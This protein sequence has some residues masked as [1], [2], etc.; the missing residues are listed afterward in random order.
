MKLDEMKEW[1]KASQKA[2]EDAPS[3]FGVF[4]DMR[5]LAPLPPDAQEAMQEGQKLFKQK[6]MV[7]SV[8]IVNNAVTKMQFMRIA[9]ETGIYAWERYIDAGTVSDWQAKGEA[10]LVEAKDPDQ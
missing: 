6:G 2:L 8:V 10:W 1:V 7:R 4:V 5:T 3:E 9:K